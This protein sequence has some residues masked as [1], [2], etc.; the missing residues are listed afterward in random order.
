L[1]EIETDRQIQRKIERERE[2]RERERERE[3]ARVLKTKIPKKNI[4][5]DIG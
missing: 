3:R 2:R 1:R 5:I 4:C